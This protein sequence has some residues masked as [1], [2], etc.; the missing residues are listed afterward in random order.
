[1][2]LNL[3]E[4]D[5][6]IADVEKAIS[7]KADYT[8]VYL[9][10]GKALEGQ[11]RIKAALDCYKL[12]LEKD[13]KNAQLLQASQELEETLNNLFSKNKVKLFTDHPQKCRKDERSAIQKLC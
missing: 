13:K 10:K 8:K 6:A 12:G 2:L 5:Q 3:T 9:R 7:F 4:Y 1:M 11:Q